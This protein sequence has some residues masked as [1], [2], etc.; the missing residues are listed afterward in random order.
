MKAAGFISNRVFDV[1]ASGGFLISDY[2]P[3]IEQLYGDSIPMFKTKDELASLL[4]YYL[5]HPEERKIKAHT[6][7]K[8]TL[9]NF[10]N[11]I[12]AKNI[13]QATKDLH[14]E[15]HGLDYSKTAI[16]IPWPQTDDV[17]GDQWLVSDLLEGFA[18]NNIDV[19]PYYYP[20]NIGFI[21]DDYYQKAGN[22]LYM[23]FKPNRTA[24]ENKY[25]RKI[26]YLYFPTFIPKREKFKNTE[27]LFQYNTQA[28]LN[29]ELEYFDLIATP[30]KKTLQDLKSKGYNAVF[31]PQFTNPQKFKLEY[32][33]DLKTDL[34]F[35]G[36]NWYE[37]TSVMYALELGYP[38][39]VYGLNWKGTIP[40]KMIKGNYI[41]NNVLNRY[42][43]SA[44]IVLND[45]ADDL[46]SM[47]LVINRL[48]DVSATGAF[49]I[50]KYSPYIEEIF[51]DSVPMFQT[52]EDLKNLL[53]YYLSHPEERQK[54][55]EKA[56]EITLKN[57]TNKIISNQFQAL[58]QTIGKD[59]L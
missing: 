13:M 37:R 20:N 8:I 6:A 31:V 25:K 33:E 18:E 14:I 58:F 51:G 56:R 27:D 32:T 15:D 46:A 42:Y 30:A 52:K 23:Q 24:A 53:D 12:I 10:T 5:S 48:Y 38:V 19:R 17:I 29:N 54:K 57:Y 59:K 47:G 39:D 3:E 50:S 40:D 16:K 36:S 26:M 9:A 44:K 28:Y 35:V 1:T 22:L 41:P 2:M 49:V 7:Q 34:L 11:D 4:A 21:T 43:S 55:A 45:Q